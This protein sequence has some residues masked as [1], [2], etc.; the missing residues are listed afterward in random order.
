MRILLILGLFLAFNANS[1]PID[2]IYANKIVNVIYLIE[3]GAKTKWPY[4]I[5]SIKTNNPRQVCLN[6]VRNNY[7]RWLKSDKKDDYITFL[8]NR[9]CPVSGDKTGLN[10]NWV[11]NLK[12]MLA[13]ENK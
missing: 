11:R 3:G 7:Q 13:K 6:T 5:R 9:F 1:E 12:I 8:G 2:P 4:G 10:K